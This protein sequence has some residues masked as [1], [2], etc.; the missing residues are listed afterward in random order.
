[1]LSFGGGSMKPN[2]GMLSTW[3]EV[4]GVVGG[5]RKQWQGG[6]LPRFASQPPEPKRQAT[7]PPARHTTP[8]QA[9][10]TLAAPTLRL[11]S[12]V[13][14]WPN[15]YAADQ[16]AAQQIQTVTAQLRAPQVTAQT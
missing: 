3:L 4:V 11:L 9:T 16:L 12:P 7:P 15:R 13:P 5:H 14:M 1:M 10:K 2:S 6:W 8:N